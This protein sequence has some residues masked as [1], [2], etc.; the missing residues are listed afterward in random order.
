MAFAVFP[1]MVELLLRKGAEVNDC[2]N[3]NGSAALHA[4][5]RTRAVEDK[6]NEVVR[7]LNAGAKNIKNYEG[8]EPFV[9]VGAH[10][11]KL[12]RL[13]LEQYQTM[14]WPFINYRWKSLL[15]LGVK[16]WRSFCLIFKP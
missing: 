14:I 5:V 4:A 10:E 11:E 2:R 6:K 12:S 3:V 16:N 13:L 15:K 8:I 9:L 7:L 1:K